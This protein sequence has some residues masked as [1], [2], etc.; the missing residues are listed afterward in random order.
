[1]TDVIRDTLKEVIDELE[2]QDP[3]SLIASMA[4]TIMTTAPTTR[5]GRPAQELTQEQSDEIVRL[6]ASGMSTYL[7]A[8]KVGLSNVTR[9]KAELAARGIKERSKNDA[10]HAGTRA[11]NVNPERVQLIRDRLD[12]G[13]NQ[14]EIGSELGISRERVRQI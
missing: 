3:G 1:M 9:V 10:Q 11:R 6:Y 5:P 4:R 8:G 14:S 7:I 2:R 13:K 12:A